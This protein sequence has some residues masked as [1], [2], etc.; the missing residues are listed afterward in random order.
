MIDPI[1]ISSIILTSGALIYKIIIICYASKCKIFKC[2]CK[3]GL[4]VERD[5]SREQSIR[6]LND[7]E[8]KITN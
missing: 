5:I 6:H 4:T 7:V 8:V 3:E 1:I 2:N